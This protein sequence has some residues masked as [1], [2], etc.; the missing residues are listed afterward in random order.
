M[1]FDPRMRMDV[2]QTGLKEIDGMR[3][4]RTGGVDSHTEAYVF[5]TLPQWRMVL[6]PVELRMCS[7]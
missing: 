1:S 3:G 4:K 6:V 5:P 2:S 7:V